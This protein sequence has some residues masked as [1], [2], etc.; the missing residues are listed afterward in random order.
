VKH[1]AGALDS[2]TMLFYSSV[3]T[4]SRVMSRCWEFRERFSLLLLYLCCE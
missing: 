4:V 1:L 2:N 3:P